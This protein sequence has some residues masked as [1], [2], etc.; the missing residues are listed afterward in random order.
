MF[1]FAAGCG[2]DAADGRPEAAGRFRI[3]K[4]FVCQFAFGHVG[5]N[6]GFHKYAVISVKIGPYDIRLRRENLVK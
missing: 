6:A 1:V 2:N 5:K 3:R 4:R